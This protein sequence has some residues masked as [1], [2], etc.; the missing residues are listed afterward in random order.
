MM[1]TN[2]VRVNIFGAEYV[3]KSDNNENY[4]IEI[5][6]YVDQKMR[7]IDRSQAITSNLKLAILAALNITDELFQ[8]KQYRDRLL[9]QIDEDSRSLNQSLQEALDLGAKIMKGHIFGVAGLLVGLCKLRNMKGLCLLAETPG[10]YPD[11]VATREVL[12]A[13]QKMLNLKINLKKLKGAA[14]ETDNIL[15]S[16]GIVSPS[17]EKKKRESDFRWFI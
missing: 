1:P 13:L 12:K 9:E 14:K 16:F 2:Q 5:T 4:I 3:L 15:Q 8:N 7:E 10:L 6:K 17:I 11:P